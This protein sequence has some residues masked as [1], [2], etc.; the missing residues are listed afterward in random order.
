[1]N[2]RTIYKWV[3]RF[4]RELTSVGEERSGRPSIVNHNELRLR[5][6]SISVSGT[7]EESAMINLHLK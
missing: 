2:K 5:N 6:R 1:M 4:K 7:T 3:K